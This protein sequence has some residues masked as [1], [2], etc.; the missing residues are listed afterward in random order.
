MTSRYPSR[1]KALQIPAST[2]QAASSRSRLAP[3]ATTKTPKGKATKASEKDAKAKAAK[4]AALHGTNAHAA[5]KVRY[6][7]S[8][9][10]PK[11]LRLP[12]NPKYPR[13]SIPH[14]PRMDQ[15]RTIVSPLNTESA[16]KK[17][18]EHN[19]LVFIVD[20][21]ANKRQ[22]KD[23][24]KKL[25]DVQAAKVNT[26]IR[27]DGKK[28]AYVRLTADHD[29]LDVAN[30]AATVDACILG[31]SEDSYN[32]TRHVI[33]AEHEEPS[34]DRPALPSVSDILSLGLKS[35]MKWRKAIASSRRP[36]RL[37][38]LVSRVD[39]NAS[40]LPIVSIPRSSIYE[41]G[42]QEPVLR[43]VSW[44]VNHD[45]AWV[46]M[47]DGAAA[48]RL[49]PA[50]FGALMGTHRIAPPPPPPGGLF[51]FL[52]GEDPYKHLQ[53]V[54]LSHHRRTLGFQDPGARYG[55]LRDED[56]RT[57]RETFFPEIARPLQKLAVPELVKPQQR[58]DKAEA[59]S[60]G[61]KTRQEELFEMLTDRLKLQD[62]LDLPMITLSNG[63]TR[64]ARIARALLADPKL[65]LLDEPLTGLDNKSRGIL[66]ALLQELKEKNAPPHVIM[67][68]RS[69]DPLPEWMTHVALIEDGGKVL[70]GKKNDILSSGFTPAM[71]QDPTSSKGSS[72]SP[73]DPS[74]FSKDSS[75]RSKDSS[76]SS[77]ESIPSTVPAPPKYKP[78]Q[79][80]EPLLE[81][82]GIDVRY[83]VTIVF[84]DIHWTIRANSR[85]HLVGENGAGE[86]PSSWAQDSQYL[87]LGRERT[88]W[89][90][91]KIG[92]HIGRVTAD[93]H[94]F[95][96]RLGLNVWDTIG[97]G[98]GDLRRARGKRGVG[99]DDDGGQLKTG[100][101]EEER[102]LHRLHEVVR[103]LGPRHWHAHPEQMTDEKFL[104]TPFAD[105]SA[106][107]QSMVLLMRA[108]VSSPELVLLDEP[109]TG[110]D[111]TMIQVAHEYLRDGG[112]GLTERQACVIVS[113]WK[114]E[115]P[116]GPEEGL[117][118]FVLANGTGKEISEEPQ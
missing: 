59:T 105:L 16:M 99:L 66:L 64:R 19:T 83:W 115:I 51:P 48:S 82:R 70:T 96:L 44:T 77:N 1:F 56:K 29:A 74:M 103:A 116:W 54:H 71:P 24:V 98:F 6:S 26:L 76:V 49:K 61:K 42:S 32:L 97:S 118:T 73:K 35:G 31:R 107:E 57:L 10:R 3:M 36:Q 17:I 18:E 21:R 104:L 53:M 47:S 67:S 23:A 85:W 86:H 79:H 88:N 14:A 38:S 95:P 12:R 4:K 112:G 89:P 7:V 100:S 28:K 52:R 90:W 108:L 58:L 109:F 13:K 9:H 80:G 84:S 8:F 63:Q 34:N 111:K 37:P 87:L 65:L 55:A 22:I 78:R 69:Q 110:M 25:Y 72:T 62:L 113:H 106:G 39:N 102:R 60:G 30:K 92:K 68:L 46:I 41:L 27:P 5:R 45:E 117:Q 43:D 114:E 15:F 75:A 101:E 50:L 91:A 40:A 11:T 81:L 33:Q 93:L 2:T 20:I 94:N